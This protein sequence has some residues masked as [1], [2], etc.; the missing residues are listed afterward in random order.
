LLLC[1]CHRLAWFFFVFGEQGSE[2]Q[3]GLVRGAGG[4][5]YFGER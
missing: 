1:G 2:R 3:V 4:V 5:L